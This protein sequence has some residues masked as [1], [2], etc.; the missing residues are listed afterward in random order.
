[1]R[2][3]ALYPSEVING[4]PG[5]ETMR[6]I[7]K[8]LEKAGSFSDGVI[9]I[10]AGAKIPDGTITYAEMLTTALVEMGWPEDRILFKSGGLGTLAETDAMV[11]VLPA[12][13]TEEV[14]VVTSWYHLPRVMFL[15][16]LQGKVVRPV[17]VWWLTPKILVRE[18]LA[19]LSTILR[20]VRP[21]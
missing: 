5:P 9:L 21:K 15:W 18:P 19:W 10:G 17:G 3:I 1:M 13:Q 2:Y 11:G 8:A 7:K 4:K 12:Y 14:W 6:R 16:L 20:L